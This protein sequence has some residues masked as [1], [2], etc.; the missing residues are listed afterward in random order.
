[1]TP[2]LFLA[3]D[4]LVLPLRFLPDSLHT[5]IMARAANHLLRGQ[6]LTARLTE[7]EGRV[8]GIAISDTGNRL[9]F[10]VRGRRLYPAPRRRADVVIRGRFEDFWLLATRREDPDTLFFQR[11][12]SIEGETET[13]VYIKNLL[14]AFEYD[15]EAHVKAVLG[16][17]LGNLLAPAIRPSQ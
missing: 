15:W 11:R 17:R 6:S 5:E 8:I 13:G 12:L 2:P 7:L 14:D 3:L 10:E 4:M 16:E 1:M 9:H